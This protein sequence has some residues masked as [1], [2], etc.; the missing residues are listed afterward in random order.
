MLPVV[1]RELKS[2]DG[3]EEKGGARKHEDKVLRPVAWC[4]AC[5]ENRGANQF[6]GKKE[7]FEASRSRTCDIVP[8]ACKW[9]RRRCRWS[10][11]RHNIIHAKQEQQR[12]VFAHS[13]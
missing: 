11:V 1:E 3:L 7:G 10:V 6:W 12:P 13:D 9:A 2:V 5:T 8:E 4:A